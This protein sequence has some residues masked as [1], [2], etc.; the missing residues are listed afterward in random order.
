MADCGV[1]HAIVGRWTCD[2]PFHRMEL[3]RGRREGAPSFQGYAVG[4]PLS[5]AGMK[6]A[7]RIGRLLSGG[8][9]QA[10]M[11]VAMIHY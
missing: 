9:K 11:P 8:T 5:A 2:P 1:A 4:L 6:K 7:T 3:C 10:K